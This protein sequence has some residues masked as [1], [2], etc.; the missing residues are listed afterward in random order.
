MMFCLNVFI[1]LEKIFN[2]DYSYVKAV[3]F[4]S[5]AFSSSLI[6]TAYPNDYW[7]KE[8]KTL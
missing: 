2:I 4:I 1:H 6:I 3:Y 8:L 5:S 7:I